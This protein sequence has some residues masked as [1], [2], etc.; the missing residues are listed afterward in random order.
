MPTH[1]TPQISGT[2]SVGAGTLVTNVGAAP[3]EVNSVLQ[4]HFSHFDADTDCRYKQL[5]TLSGTVASVTTTQA[6]VLASPAGP[7][8]VTNTGSVPIF[9]GPTG[10]SATSTNSTRVAPGQTVTVFPVAGVAQYAVT[11]SGTSSLTYT[12]PGAVQLLPYPLNLLYLLYHIA[13]AHGTALS[14]GPFGSGT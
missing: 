8:Q 1:M 3:A 6:Q 10:V 9:I 7:Y 2:A 5:T 12:A 4:G 14:T 13:L 11:Q